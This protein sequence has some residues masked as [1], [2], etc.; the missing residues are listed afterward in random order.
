MA[1]VDEPERIENTEI[2]ATDPAAMACELGR[3]DSP[4][5]CQVMTAE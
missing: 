1:L 4:T 3:S 5:W 2:E